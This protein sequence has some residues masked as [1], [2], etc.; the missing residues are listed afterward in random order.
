M[1]RRDTVQNAFRQALLEDDYTSATLYLVGYPSLDPNSANAP[2]DVVLT[3]ERRNKILDRLAEWRAYNVGTEDT[4]ARLVG[5]ADYCQ[6]CGEYRRIFRPKNGDTLEVSV[7]KFPDHMHICQGCWFDLE[8]EDTPL[9]IRTWA[10]LVSVLESLPG[11]H[12]IP[13]P[14]KSDIGEVRRR[15]RPTIRAH[16]PLL[17]DCMFLNNVPQLEIAWMNTETGY[18]LAAPINRPIGFPKFFRRIDHGDV[19]DFCVQWRENGRY[20]SFSKVNT[21]PMHPEC[22]A[23]AQVIDIDYLTA[24]D[25][26]ASFNVQPKF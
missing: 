9:S 23:G 18:R 10:M 17:E 13:R 8:S 7:T 11:A 2:N 16:L 24:F 4:V 15:G 3:E 19:V 26:N 12:Y 14:R 22:L 5:R 20:H 6:R 25:H 1:T 21:W